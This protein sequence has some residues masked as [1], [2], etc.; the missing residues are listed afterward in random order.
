MGRRR[1]EGKGERGKEHEGVDR[2]EEKR[3]R[4]E[5]MLRVIMNRDQAGEEWKGRRVNIRK[6]VRE[7]GEKKGSG[8]DGRWEGENREE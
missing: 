3:R 7:S 8:H 2:R 5:K 6:G 1:G 4:G